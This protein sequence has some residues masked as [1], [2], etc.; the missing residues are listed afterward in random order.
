M[1]RAHLSPG[2]HRPNPETPLHHGTSGM[3]VAMQ[4]ASSSHH[5]VCKLLL[6][7]ALITCSLRIM[8]INVHTVSS[9]P[10][11]LAVLDAHEHGELAALTLMY[12]TKQRALKPTTAYTYQRS[13]SVR[14]PNARPNT[15]FAM[16]ARVTKAPNAQNRRRATSSSARPSCGSLSV[17]K[18]STSK[19]VDT[20]RP[21]VV[22]V[23]ALEFKS[24][25]TAPQKFG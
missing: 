4:N 9:V 17:I 13:G 18:S 14:G 22:E 5:A 25:D 21:L 19:I 10:L 11:P 12:R 6:K 2:G 7:V 23:C 8:T 24:C 16:L 3:L 15:K 20:E 1:A